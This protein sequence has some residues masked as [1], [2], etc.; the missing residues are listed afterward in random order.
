M[1]PDASVGP[2]PG[3]QEP[4]NLFALCIAPAGSGKTQ[5]LQLVV[6]HPLD[7]VFGS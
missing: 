2:L 1:G 7:T 5:C 3:Y 4:V 6:Q